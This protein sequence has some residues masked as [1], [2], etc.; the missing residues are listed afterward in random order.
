VPAPLDQRAS[1]RRVRGLLGDARRRIATE[2]VNRI[3]L[4]DLHLRRAKRIAGY[5]PV[6]SELD[7]GPVLKTL[8]RGRKQVYLP[9]VSRLPG[10]MDFALLTDD[11]PL[12]RNR[13]G[14][15]Q[16]GS[17][18]PG[19]GARFLDVVLLPLLAFDLN[20]NRLGSGAGYYDRAFAFR[21]VRRTWRRPWLLGVAFDCQ[22]VP[23]LEPQP[24]DVP[25]D[26]L[27]TETR[28]IR[29]DRGSRS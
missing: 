8:A 20:G 6:G 10:R 24:W 9:R 28:L 25:L 12:L 26:G 11:A 3:A 19:I 2:A 1:L 21:R 16:P 14:I 7:P 22:E 17:T 18:A 27:A 13:Y 29:F 4:T 5:S 15:L 23:A